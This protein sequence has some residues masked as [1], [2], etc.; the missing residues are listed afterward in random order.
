MCVW[1]GVSTDFIT[2]KQITDF[3]ILGLT[4]IRLFL[5][6]DLTACNLMTDLQFSVKA[7]TLT[8]KLQIC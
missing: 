2:H 5:H 1:G 8:R 3:V 6:L 7:R 4:H